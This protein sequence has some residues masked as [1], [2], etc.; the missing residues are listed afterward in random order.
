MPTDSTAKKRTLAVACAAVV[1]LALGGVSTA[2]AVAPT[3]V[4]AHSSLQ[5]STDG[6]TWRS[7]PDPV[8]ASW[9]CEGLDSAARTGTVDPCRMNPGDEIT[10]T[11]FVRNATS[12]QTGTFTVGV[13]DYDISAHGVFEVS[14]SIAHGRPGA[15]PAYGALT[16]VGAAAKVP[17]NA[18][19]PAI[20][21]Q[22]VTSTVLT[23]G[24]SVLVVDRVAVP[25]AV[26]NEAMQQRFSPRVWIDFA[27]TSATDS[28]GDGLSNSDERHLGSDPA[29][30]YDPVPPA[31][32]VV[33]QPFPLVDPARPGPGGQGP[34]GGVP[35]IELPPGARMTVDGSTLPPGLTAD[36]TGAI[37]GIPTRPGRFDVSLTITLA[38]GTELHV[39]R[40]ITIFSGTEYEHSPIPGLATLPQAEVGKRYGPVAVDGSGDG[41]ALH[42]HVDESTVPPGLSVEGGAI[43][44]TPTR[45]GR[46]TVAIVITLT[47][48]SLA[49]VYRTLVVSGDGGSGFPPGGSVDDLGLPELIVPVGLFLLG[50]VLLGQSGSLAVPGVGSLAT[51]GVGSLTDAGSLRGVGLFPP[52]GS[53]PRTGSTPGTG[54][55]PGGSTGL[56]ATTTAPRPPQHT[57]AELAES[58]ISAG[59]MAAQAAKNAAPSPE[60]ARSNS[61]VR[62]RLAY[63]GADVAS[64]VLWALT[65]A[66]C[67]ITLLLIARRRTTDQH[68]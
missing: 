8:L 37:S 54:S 15:P 46:Y 28:D 60:W 26:G 34:R 14:S 22:A 10:R 48:G 57:D 68:E 13:G 20:R 51:G 3:D 17:G 33:G 56:G 40:P 45:A 2:R 9:G 50:G 6:V 58:S 19:P 65:A 61:E 5:F 59:A 64:L 27:A 53:T 41:A 24:E 55:L 49:T 30:P 18:A 66:A 7:E 35:L 25:E 62:H 23:P 63:T 47:D 42:P 67:G 4:D 16:V 31:I 1:T 39:T 52:T 29:D 12:A 43:V 44:G 32:G 21:G 11:Y 38:D 36:T